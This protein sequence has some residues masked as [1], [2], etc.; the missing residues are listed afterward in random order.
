MRRKL[1]ALI[2]VCALVLLGILMLRAIRM[3][4]VGYREQA[5][6]S[7]EMIATAAQSLAF[8]REELVYDGRGELD[9]MEGVTATDVDGS[10]I[11]EQVNAVITGRSDVSRKDGALFRI[12]LRRKGTDGPAI[13]CDAGI[14]GAPALCGGES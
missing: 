4:R 12:P 10:D 1:T 11:T 7:G 13:P 5:A 8:Q 9:L 2:G 14:P 6:L 3:D